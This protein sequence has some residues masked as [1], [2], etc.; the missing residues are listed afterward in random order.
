MRT[1]SQAD[2]KRLSESQMDGRACIVCGRG[3]RPMVPIYEETPTSTMVFRCSGD[4][5]AVEAELVRQWISATITKQG[6][7]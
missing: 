2:E 4:D 3:D 1:K 7:E 6:E 5:C